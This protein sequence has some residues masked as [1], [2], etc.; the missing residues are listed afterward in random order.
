M[1]TNPL[2]QRDSL[3]GVAFFSDEICYRINSRRDHS[4]TI[5]D[6]GTIV[7]LISRFV[8]K[9][10]WSFSAVGCQLISGFPL[11]GHT[12]SSLP[13]QLVAPQA[14]HRFSGNSGS[15][16]MVYSRLEPVVRFF[17]GFRIVRHGPAP[18]ASPGSSQVVF[19]LPESGKASRID[20]RHE[21]LPF[22]CQAPGGPRLQGGLPSATCP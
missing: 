1:L 8:R 14:L 16:S 9:A 21:R 20:F 10:K 5:A 17:F 11:P 3:T 2:V 12:P 7:N 19:A 15:V 13:P 18:S 22:S 4:M 6:T